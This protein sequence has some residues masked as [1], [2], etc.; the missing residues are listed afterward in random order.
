MKGSCDLV[1]ASCCEFK[2]AGYDTLLY[3]TLLY[4]YS[5]LFCVGTLIFIYCKVNFSNSSNTAKL[6]PN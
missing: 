3:P 2:V 5:V 4:S 1:H 6:L